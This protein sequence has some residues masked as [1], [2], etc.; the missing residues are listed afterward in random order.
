MIYVAS[1][2]P[3]KI[4]SYQTARPTFAVNEFEGRHLQSVQD[5]FLKRYI[6]SMSSSQGCGCAF[7]AKVRGTFGE[8]EYS[9][10]T[11]DRR[12]LVQYLIDAL[13]HQPSVELFACW[14]GHEAAAPEHHAQVRPSDL[15][16]S[17]QYFKEMQ[18]LLVSADGQAQSLRPTANTRDFVEDLTERTRAPEK[19]LRRNKA[20]FGD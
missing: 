3:L 11:E 12:L 18:L 2:R 7:K 1:A 15:F 19:R 10:D 6:Y 4:I 8:A 5:Q 14:N 20:N 16:D 17:E 13:Q 9:D